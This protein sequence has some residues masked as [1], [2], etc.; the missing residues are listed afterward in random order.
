MK[1][2]P[3]ENLYD[4][5]ELRQ[6]KN[7]LFPNQVGIPSDQLPEVGEYGSRERR[8]RRIYEEYLEGLSQREIG[9]RFGI[10]ERSIA[11]I[12]R[13]ER[14]R[15]FYENLR[16]DIEAGVDIETLVLEY[17][18]SQGDIAFHMRKV[19]EGGRQRY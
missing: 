13:R 5:K 6:P 19:L 18:M 17:G 10:A 16:R 7:A 3:K 11:D 15:V 4:A 12:I 8:N 1:D 14:I 9:E 2:I